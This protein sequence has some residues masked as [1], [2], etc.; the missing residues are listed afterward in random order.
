MGAVRNT[1][2]DGWRAFAVVGVM[3]HHWAP[4]GW[5]GPFPFEIG[6][7]FF[8]TLTGFLI[9]RIL[10]RDRAAGEA[11]GGPWRGQA[12]RD[13]LRRRFARILLPCYAAM[14]FAAACGAPDLRAHPWVY[15]LH[16]SNLHMAGMEGWPSGT[17]H[18]WTL[19]IQMQFYLVWPALVFLAPR[20]LLGA[21]FVACLLLAPLSRVVIEGGFP[22]IH[23]PGAVSSSALDYFGAGALLAWVLERGPERG[24]PWIARVGW[25]AFA[26]YVLL[27][28][29]Q[30]A[31]RPLAALAPFQQTF[32]SL[33][34]AALIAATL[35]GLGGWPG[36]ALEHPAT[37]HL[38]QLSYG[39]YL[40][41]TAMPLFL[42][43]VAPWLWQ[44][45]LFPGTLPGLRIVAFALASYA[46]A[47]LCWRWLEGPERLRLTKPRAGSG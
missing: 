45:P 18:F 35:R 25:V 40:F 3:W 41:H 23:H 5:R 10:L 24:R 12:W 33:A 11:G 30:E 38:G 17:A 34:L 36:R 15:I 6:L 9:T 27:Y 4:R 13:F 44:V 42:G 47:R 46:A 26:A 1:Q 31:G 28:T 19:A 7:F 21:C 14:A 22:G 37:Q 2:L 20:R 29:L 43:S 16:I 39:L 8:L 32:L